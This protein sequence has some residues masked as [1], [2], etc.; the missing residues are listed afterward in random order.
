VRGLLRQPAKF[1]KLANHMPLEFPFQLG[2][3]LRVRENIGICA[4]DNLPADIRG[5]L[6]QITQQ[7]ARSAQDP[8]CDPVRIQAQVEALGYRHAATPYREFRGA[9]SLTHEALR[10]V[11]SGGKLLKVAPQAFHDVIVGPSVLHTGGNSDTLPGSLA[12]S[13]HRPSEQD[14][15]CR[16]GHG[17]RHLLPRI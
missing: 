6:V 15:H 12:K 17:S 5:P 4:A 16:I 9:E 13:S 8:V 11:L 2:Q 1:G 14:S 3:R 10:K 7:I